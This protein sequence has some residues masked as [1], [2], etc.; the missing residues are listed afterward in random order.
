MNRTGLFVVSCMSLVTTSMVFAIRGAVE[1]DMTTTF[2]ISK[3]Q[4]GLLWGPSFSG[5]T[6]SI[7][8]CGLFVDLLG[9]RVLHALS[10][11]AYLTG[12][13][14]VL[15]APPPLE[16][17]VTSIWAHQGTI[18]LFVGFLLMGLAQGIVEGVINPLIATIYSNNK[19]HKLNVLH[20][21][22]PGGMI[23]GGL[24]AYGL[25]KAGAGSWMSEAGLGGWRIKFGL[26]M[27]PALFYLIGVLTLKYPKTERVTSGVSTGEMFS[28]VF[29]PLFLLLLACMWLTAATELGPDQWFPSLMGKLTGMNTDGILF[30][31]YTAGLMFVL[32]SFAGPIAHAISPPAMLLGCAIL[33]AAG[34]YWLGSLQPGTS[35]AIAFAAATVF[36]VGKTFFWPTMLGVTSEQFPR[37]GSLL[38]N[39]MGGTGMLSASL[40]LP[41]IGKNFGQAGAGEALKQVAILPLILIVVFGALTLYF[42]MRG[43]YRVERLAAADASG[44]S[45]NADE[46]ATPL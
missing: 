35:V 44:Q 33:S 1:S 28:Q 17:P 10:A 19:V 24:L 23:I 39:M 20:A 9:M 30:L 18:M 5:F 26:I 38:M 27:V 43:G 11:V 32:R 42:Q 34:L 31:V 3:E 16:S 8:L 12:V 13:T 36:G 6:I 29:R 45:P 15:V 46:A 4:M 22:W 41:W 37:G 7:F 14:L 40:A 2:Q 21:W 25:S